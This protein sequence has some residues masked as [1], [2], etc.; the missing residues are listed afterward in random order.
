MTD[1]AD[2]ERPGAALQNGGVPGH[3]GNG[4]ERPEGSRPAAAPLEAEMPH[5]LPPP[6]RVASSRSYPQRR[7]DP[8]VLAR[9]FWVL[10]GLIALGGLGLLLQGLHEAKLRRWA[11]EIEEAHGPVEPSEETWTASEPESKSEPESVDAEP[12]PSPPVPV[13]VLPHTVRPPL[14]SAPAREPLRK[15]VAVVISPAPN[16]NFYAPGQINGR[17][18]RFVV[19]TGAS[20]V[21]IPDR[22][23]WQL[24]LT[25]GRYLQSMTAN[26][27]AGMYETRVKSLSIGS[28]QLSD[29]TAVLYPNAADDTVLLGMTALREVRMAYE[30][31]RMVLQKE[32][33]GEPQ[34]AAEEPPPAAA[35]ALKRPV[36]D[37]MGRSKVVDDRVLR[38]MQGLGPAAD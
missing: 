17:D 4:Q 35:P 37:C 21:A 32:I 9:L 3:G 10:P 5:T 33:G 28:I 19:D 30:N 26:G 12:E 7:R 8:G 1:P 29:V 38:C 25:H 27:I 20:T 31:G 36:Q 23:R 14:P 11:A 15:S 6:R 22:L 24:G 2:Q 13:P 18:V 34:P 16:G